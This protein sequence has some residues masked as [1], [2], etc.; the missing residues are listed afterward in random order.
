[1]FD[2]VVN[3]GGLQRIEGFRPGD[4]QASE[5]FDTIVN[6]GG[7]QYAQ[8]GGV[9]YRTIVN[10][11]GQQYAYD[12]GSTHDVVINGGRQYVQ[13]GGL[14]HDTV[15]NDAGMQIVY[16]GGE[17]QGTVLNQGGRQQVY[18]T[19]NGVGQAR[20]TVINEAGQQI[21][22]D[23]GVATDTLVNGGK[24]SVYATEKGFGLAHN[25]VVQN[26]GVQSVYKQGVAT[27]T[28]INVGGTQ[29]VQ[30]GGRVENTV[31]NGGVFDVRN[32]GVVN[33]VVKAN[34][35]GVWMNAAAT[36]INNVADLELLG[37]DA[38]LKIG[39]AEGLEGRQQAGLQT[40]MNNGKVLFSDVTMDT[41]QAKNDFTRM[42]LNVGKLSGSGLFG[43]HA[44]VGAKEGDV[45]NV[46][47]T[48]ATDSHNVL[49]IANNGAAEAT[50]DDVLTM[51]TTASG[52]D[53][54][55]F[56]LAHQ[57]EQGGYLFD[58]RQSGHDW[59][60]YGV[61]RDEG[62]EEGKEPE[63]GG[64]NGGEEGGNNGG[65]ELTESAQGGGGFLNAS[66]LLNYVDTQSL[67]QRMG[68]LR[69]DGQRRGQEGDVWV[70]GYTGQLSG[71]SGSALR[72]MDMDYDGVQLGF[73]R[74]GFDFAGEGNVYL[75]GFVG[76]SQGKPKQDKGRSKVESN[77]IGLYGVYTAPDGTYVDGVVKYTRMSNEF[78]G[79]NTAQERIKGKGK[80]NGYSL[81]VEAGK[82]VDVYQA[83]AGKLYVEPQMQVTFG[84]QGG[85]TVKVNDGLNVRLNGYDSI[86]GRASMVLG[87]AVTETAVPFNVYVKTGLV[88]EFDGDV[89]FYLNKSRESHSFKGNFWDNE[90]GI[91]AQ[92]KK[93]HAVHADFGYASGD[94]FDKKQVNLNYRYAF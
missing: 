86:L 22:L 41:T 47:D 30:S 21:V 67:M 63:E 64:N 14:A 31:V 35:G 68:D 93:Q 43:M 55:Q 46:T 28:Q 49:Y 60:L 65:G 57:V 84:H 53:A 10:A 61:Q 85:T 48:L 26:G 44:D 42:T 51:V 6:S 25:T 38:Y 8:G 29:V 20:G 78:E 70:K 45:L 36:S 82:R 66:Y 76:H 73:D 74:T 11:G 5:G 37:A 75:G 79:Q 24:Q 59:E 72:G 89:D 33:G 80:T 9:A 50:V 2:T 19:A 40:L 90:I 71:F 58:L 13:G 87:Y 77:S 52:G 18:A 81:S 88:R 69:Q 4:N 39:A 62:E 17:S 92:F 3:D 32:D 54:K 15:V 12:D 23:G 34:S 27:N 91:S 83:Q 7:K 16:S 1:A 94:R 56:T